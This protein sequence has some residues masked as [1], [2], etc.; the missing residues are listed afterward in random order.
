MEF[1]SIPRCPKCGCQYLTTDKKGFGLGKAIVGTVLAGPAGALA[2]FIGSRRLKL[3]CLKC[4]HSWK[5]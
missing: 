5:V 1:D 2:G 3:T 4:G